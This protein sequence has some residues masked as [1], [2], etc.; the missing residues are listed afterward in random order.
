MS[1]PTFADTHNLVAF[2]EKPAESSG[3]EQIIDFLKSKPIYY[4]L[5]V[6]PT[7]YVSCVKQFWATTK[8]KRVN[9][10][11]QI[12]ALVDKKKVIIT[13]DRIR[14]DLRFDD[15]EGTA[16]LLNEAIFKGLAHICAKTT[17]WNEFSSTMTSAIISAA[18]MGD[19]PVQTHQTPIVDQPST[20]RPQKKQKP[21]RTQRKEAEVS[22]DESGDEDH[23]PTPSNDLLPSGEDRYTL[24]ELMVFYTSLQEAKDAQSKE[25]VALKKK[26]SISLEKSNKN[27]I[28]L[29]DVID[30]PVNVSLVIVIAGSKDRPP[31]L[32]PGNY[33]QWK[34]RIKRYIDTKPNHELI[35]HCLKNPPYKFTCVDKEVSIS[36]GSPVTRTKS[37]M[38]TYKTVSQDI[39]DQLN[40]KAEAVQIILTGIDND[41]YSTVDACPNAC[42]MNRGKA[43]VNSP[44]PIY[45]Q[46]PSMV[47]ED[48][49]MSKDEE[50]DKLM[51]LISLSSTGY[52]NQRI[53]NVAGARETV[54][55]TVVQKSGIQCYNCKE[56]GHVTRECQKPKRVKDAA[57]HR[58]KMLLCKQEEA[59]IQLNA[60]QANW[61]DDIDDELEDQEL[62]AHY[63]YMAQ[64]Q[65][66]SLDAADSEPIFDAE[67]LQK[68][69]MMS[70]SFETL[71]KHAINLE[72]DLQRCQEKIKNEKS[73]KENLSKEFRKEREQYFKIQDLKAQLQD[74]GIVISELKKL[75]EKLKGKSVDTK[76]EKSSVIRQPNAFKSQRPSVLGKPTTFSNYFERKVFSKLKSVTQNN[77]SNDF[78]KPVT[79]QT[80]PP[81]K[82]S[83]LKNTNVL[84]LGMYKLHTK[85]NQARTSDLNAKTLNVNFVSATCDKCVLNDNH[86]MCVLNSVAKPLKK[87]VASE[88]NQKPRN[89]TKKLY[90]H[91]SK[92]CSWWYPKFTPSGYKWKPKSRQEN[93]NP[94]LVKIVLF[95]I[96]SGCSKHMTG[97]LKLLINFVEKF[98][99]TVKFGND[100]IAPIL[101]YGDLVQGAVRIK[102]VYY[103]EGLNHNLL[104]IGQFY[105]VD[106]EVAFRKSTCYI[107]DLKGNDLLTGSRCTDLYSITLQDTNSPNP[108]C[109]MAKATSSQAWLWHRRLSHLNFDTI[110]LLSKND[111]V[112]ALPIRQRSSLFFLYTWTYFLRSKN[113]TLEVLIDFLRLVQRGLQAYM[114]SDHVSSDPVPECQ[115]M[116][117]EHYSLSPATQCQENVTQADKTVTTSNELDLLFSPMFDEL[118]NG[119]SKVMS[120]SFAVSTADAPNQRQQ[121]Q[122]TPLNNHITPESTCHDPTQLPA[123]TSN[124]NMNQAK[125]VEEY[126]QVE[127]DEF[128]NIFCTPVQD[129]GEMS[130]RHV[131][132]SN[133]HTFYQHHPSEHRWSKDHPL[134]QVIGNPSQ[135]VRTRRQLESNGELCMFALTVSRT[136]PKTIKEAMTNSA[137]IESMQE[138]LHQ[139]DRLDNTVIRNKSHLVAKGYAQKEG[140]DF[141]ESFAPV[142]RLEVVSVGTPMAT[143]HLDANLSGTPVDQMKY[144]SMVG[145]LMYLTTS[146][147]DIM[148]ATCY[149][150]RYQAKLTEKHLT[151][152]KQIFRYLK[153]TIHMGL[154]Y[155]KDTGFKLTAFSDSNH[156]GCLDSRKSTSG[157]IQFLGGD[158]LV[159]WSSKKQDCTSMSSAE[160]ETEYQLAGM[161]T[162]ALPVER[163]KYL[164]R[165]LGGNLLQPLITKIR[166]AQIESRANKRSIINLIR[167]QSMYNTCCSPYNNIWYKRV[168]RIFLENLPEHPSDTK[169]F[170]VN[171]EILLEPTLNKLLGRMIEE[172]DQDD[173]IVLDVDTQGRKNNNEMFGVN[174][175]SGE[176]VL[177]TTT[178][179]HEEQIIKDISTAEPVITAGEVVTTVAD[180]VSAAP[181]TNV[182]K[183]EITMAQALAAL[184]STK[185]KVVVQEQ[186]VITTFPAAAIIVT[187]AVL[188]LRAKEAGEQET[189]RLGRAQQDEE[190]NIS[191]D[192]IQA[193]ME[194]DSL[195]A[196]ML[197]SRERE[198]FS[199]EQKARLEMRKVNNF[200][201]MDS[202][203]QKR[204]RKEAQES[205][206]KRTV[207]S[208]EHDI[209]KKQKVDENVEPVIDDTE[210]LKKCMETVPDDGDE[211]LIKA[212]PLSSRSPTI[213]DYKIYKE[214][215][216]TYF[217]IIRAYSNSQVYQTFEKMFKNFNREDLEVLTL[218]TMFEHHVEDV[219]W[220]Y[221]QGLAMVKNWKLCESC[222]VYCITMQGT[223]YYLL[224]K[225]FYP[226]TR[227]TL[228]Q[229]WN[230]VTL[231][232][233]TSS[234]G[235]VMNLLSLYYLFP[236][237]LWF[238]WISFDYRVPLDNIMD[239]IN[240]DD[241]TIE[242]YLRLTQENQTPSMVKKVDDMTIAE[243][244]EYEERMN[245]DMELDEEAGYI[246][247]EESVMS[248]HEAI[249]PA[250]AINTQSF[251]EELSSEEDLDEWLK[252]KMEKHMKVD[253]KKSSEAME[254]TINND[255]FTSNLPYK[256]VTD[257]N[258]G[259]K[260]KQ[261]RTKPS[262][263]LKAWKSQKSIKV[264]RKST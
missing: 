133:M 72:I 92:A 127:N 37:H 35:H 247:N 172:I 44:Q 28:G 2:L 39:R 93:V 13:E 183:N 173:E 259:T 213:I 31:M 182:T 45:D 212:T 17:V 156:A 99:G 237:R 126:A 86:D 238:R 222:G 121:Q 115:R 130:S 215:N 131:D 41:I 88:S 125:M 1:T 111:I 18:N 218:K 142:A 32:A 20:F 19:T 241:L 207:D 254:D 71:Q 250:H 69:K 217:K 228:H 246:T 10:Q 223:I 153:D 12:Q 141:E 114:A 107:R 102:M 189:T 144:R 225:K 214:G 128:I 235:I 150:A 74:K 177:D 119:S 52:E 201:A 81:N 85:H 258:K 137:W 47:A 146:K 110:N 42:E 244:I 58:E 208:L 61:R 82:K 191:W 199:E 179:E 184:K 256:L 227:N 134:E 64:L 55:S 7:I 91:I 78:S 140:V 50:I 194:A 46:E 188:T 240:I 257:I 251:K 109:L 54:G 205:G 203:A 148:H 253:L 132:T 232:L 155:P 116:A 103:V 5:T 167:I 243:Y 149:C 53:S 40:A 105:D 104:S 22:H 68:S 84:A 166:C 229:L 80:L 27:V 36:E 112:V 66:I 186:E 202:K 9:D 196:K 70:K 181:T 236:V 118:L 48:D 169:V 89:I 129:Q 264:N 24:N 187:T 120:K 100:Q 16:C 97:N 158:K 83:I 193:M 15:A 101:G 195:L 108:I 123:V 210:E 220:T 174:D 160:A 165:R 262:T 233:S 135:S 176:V 157:G 190:T 75:I 90:E 211:V 147:P 34:S 152:V 249:N 151:A 230:D 231:Q 143:K 192:I 163:F 136:K 224:V 252:A 30:L 216:K 6:N 26:V 67:P 263:K 261:N 94:N 122:T 219:I 139:F 245:T 77:V 56:F 226:L 204:C 198:E 79:A 175:L 106:L 59:G 178:R 221:Q 51:A 95:I 62:E 73:F 96:D 164:V 242:Q 162:K 113:E 138:E 117:L 23:V 239:G 145:A 260:F 33:V 154:W 209:Y 206:T 170:T 3:F 234:A 197:Q 49:E 60:E 87:T 29:K 255:N 14:S 43:I 25:I 21:K 159:S 76:F 4:V 180:K 185:P 98:L 171:M 200:I 168:L 38:E 57:Y 65:E 8:V 63:M 124:E 248:E 11:E 161:F